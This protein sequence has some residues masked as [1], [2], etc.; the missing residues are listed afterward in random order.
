[1]YVVHEVL[2]WLEDVGGGGGL[3]LNGWQGLDFLQEW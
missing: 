2:H 3:C 1:V